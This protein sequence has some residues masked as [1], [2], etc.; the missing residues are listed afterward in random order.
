MKRL[1]ININYVNYRMLFIEYAKK[2][3]LTREE[4]KYIYSYK[5]WDTLPFKT[6]Y[7]IIRN[8]LEEKSS[9]END[10]V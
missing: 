3:N 5:E 8:F 9:N 2:V 7:N 6:K 4:S 10:T 1:S